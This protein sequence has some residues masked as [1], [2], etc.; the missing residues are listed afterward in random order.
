MYNAASLQSNPH[1]FQTWI[2]YPPGISTL[3]VYPTSFHQAI[4]KKA[5]T[6]GSFPNDC[7]T[8]LVCERSLVKKRQKVFQTKLYIDE[9]FHCLNHYG[10]AVIKRHEYFI[11]SK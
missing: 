5:S 6:T 7:V 4:P 1:V 2:V 10:G 8:Q 3:I 11:S 9:T